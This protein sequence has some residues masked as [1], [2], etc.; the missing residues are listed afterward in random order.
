MMQRIFHMKFKTIK[1]I[2]IFFCRLT[3]EIHLKFS[4]QPQFFNPFKLLLRVKALSLYYSLFNEVIKLN[5]I[6]SYM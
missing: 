5:S 2:I 6:T 3:R 1:T 4:I